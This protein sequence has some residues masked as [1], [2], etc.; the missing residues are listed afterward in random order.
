MNIIKKSIAFILIAVLALSFCGCH[1]PNEV[2][3]KIGDLSFT[4]G[5]YLCALIESD[6]SAR[7]EIDT[8]AQTDDSIDTSKENY[9]FSQKLED[10][11]FVTYVK[12]NA[13]TKLKELASF[14]IKAK[15][16]NLKISEEELANA[17]AYIS[18]YWSTMSESFEN[19]GVSKETFTE[20]F[21]DAY[22]ADAYFDFIYDKGGKK[23][24]ASADIE[25][26]K[27]EN[28]AYA[29]IL[30]KDISTAEDS[31]KDAAKKQFE[32]FEKA[33]KNNKST[34]KDIYE[35][36]NNITD[37]QKQESYTSVI[38][39][40][41]TDYENE[42]FDTIKKMSVDEIKYIKTDISLTIVIKRDL[43]KATDQQDALNK[44]II[45]DLKDEEFNKDMKT[46]QDS[47]K[48]TENKS[49]TK[50]FN[51]KKFKYSTQTPT[52]NA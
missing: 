45:H 18:Y 28:Y 32:E 14:K 16:N 11:D 34:F 41:K 48:V 7:Q 12:D 30:T 19:N 2:A 27:K 40:S 6:M 44:Q 42:N 24:V 47:L 49:A 29:D 20:Y 35:S 52:V 13:L 5:Y 3:I 23:E 50:R 21:K 9:Y 37:E 25:K 17:D 10:K 38:G 46:F 39:S 43:A 31:E 33:L 26:Y 36:F 22:Y 1:K 51:I 8:K 15:E 4:S